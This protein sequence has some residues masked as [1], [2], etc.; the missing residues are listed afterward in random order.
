MTSVQLGDY[1][2]SCVAV[3]SLHCNSEVIAPFRNWSLSF[4][5]D[6]KKQVWQSLCKWGCF[7]I[8]IWI[9]KHRAVVGKVR[10]YLIKSVTW[11]PLSDSS[12]C[13]TIQMQFRSSSNHIQEKNNS[14]FHEDILLIECFAKHIQSYCYSSSYH[15]YHEGGHV[16][17]FIE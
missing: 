4:F 12:L 3:G 14:G 5:N 2:A 11:P 7:T 8:Q 6:E 1:Y 10:H 15:Y 13:V 9:V 17:D 16:T